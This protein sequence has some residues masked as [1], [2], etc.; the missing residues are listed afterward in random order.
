M[1]RGSNS[2]D[3]RSARSELPSG[4]EA[5]R[6]DINR[7][8]NET[9]RQRSI[10]AFER[11]FEAKSQYKSLGKVNA[12]D[13]EVGNGVIK[14]GVLFFRDEDI[15]KI[16]DEN[17]G[18]PSQVAELI[19]DGGGEVPFSMF[20]GDNNLVN[21]NAGE[22]EAAFDKSTVFVFNNEMGISPID[23]PNGDDYE[24]DDYEPGESS[25]RD[26]P[27]TSS[28][29]RVYINDGDANEDFLRVAYEKVS[30]AS[31]DKASLGRLRGAILVRINEGK[32]EVEERKESSEDFWRD[33][34]DR[35]RGQQRDE[36]RGRRNEDRYGNG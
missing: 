6:A 22:A 9:N 30:G 5:T 14:D 35:D 26:D 32:K 7:L 23:L 13:G 20:P 15:E 24:I 11:D 34:E 18:T 3:G 4:V 29:G 27:G 31:V 25:T 21:K 10:L 17:F 36:E 8:N 19:T 12:G 28:S 33:Y 1:A 16:V 2:R